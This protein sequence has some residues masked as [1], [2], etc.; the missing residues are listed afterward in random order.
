MKAKGKKKVLV[1]GGAG[2]IGSHLCD[3][4]AKQ[5]WEVTI[6]D[7]FT[8]GSVGNIQHL[9]KQT[10]QK[11]K[12]LKGDCTNPIHLEKA[13]R[14]VETVFHFAA[15]PEARLELCDPQTCFQQNI[16]ATYVLLQQLRN[17]PKLHTI[18]FAS[19]STVYGEPETIPTPENYAPL[20]PI[21]L[22][23]ASKLASEALISAYAHTYNYTAVIYRLA[24]TVGPRSQHGVIHD[25]IQKLNKNPNQLEILGDGTQTKSYLY[26]NDC[27]EA[28]L[29][30]LEKATEQV[31]VFNVGSEDQINVRDIAQIV[32]EE[33]QLKNVKLTY[34]GGV[35]GGRGWKGDVKNML[36]DISKLKAKGWKPKYNSAQTIR[37]T[38]KQIVA[39]SRFI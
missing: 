12:L 3:S 27:I 7:N 18:V 13:L 14:N 4:L 11:V 21:S 1:T 34:T 19:T 29:L 35:D 17:N 32:I 22:Y 15:N 2:F 10:P 26:I 33:M 20:K 39:E 5:Y 38:A 23:G 36:L 6:L 8:A 16:Y 24:N 28:M 30:A 31:E 9:L 25:F 37:K